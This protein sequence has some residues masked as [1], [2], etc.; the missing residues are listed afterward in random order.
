MSC[1]Q[2]QVRQVALRAN[3]CALGRA[4]AVAQQALQRRAVVC[5][6]ADTGV[7]RKPAVLVAEHLFGITT[8]QQ[9]LLTK[10]CSMRRRKVACLWTTA[11]ASIPKPDPTLALEASNL[12]GWLA[13]ALMLA[14][15]ACD[16]QRCMRMLALAANV[17]FIVNGTLHGLLPVVILHTLLF[18]INLR[19]LVGLMGT[20]AMCGD[21]L[22]FALDNL[23]NH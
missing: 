17:C 20:K 9:P 11:S 22:E 21:V 19:K 13:T 1:E 2:G 4:H 12:F 3:R 15:F 18:P 6:D 10:A 7:H 23:Q 16:S 5:F 8:Q 14:T